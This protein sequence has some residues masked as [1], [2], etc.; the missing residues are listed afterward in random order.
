MVCDYALANGARLPAWTAVADHKFTA[1]ALA[2]GT[3][4][5][6]FRAAGYLAP[7]KAYLH[8]AGEPMLTR[9]LRALRSAHSIGRIRCVTPAAAIVTLPDALGLYD[10]VIE[11]GM[12]LIDSLLTGLAGLDP[13]ERVLL[14]AT[15][16]PLVT[17]SAIDA[18]AALA[19]A[20]PCDIGYGFVERTAHE[21]EYPE[22]RHT[23]VRLQQGV[24]CGGG[25][26]VMRAGA[27]RQVQDVL[28]RLTAAR[29]SPLKLAALFSYGLLFKAAM[30]WLRIEQ[31]ER[32]ADQISGLTCRGLLCDRPELA[33]NVDRLDDLRTVEHIIARR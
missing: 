10:E 27:A 29:K 16:M 4:E 32:R 22:V 2:G 19:S 3:L 14:A 7:N 8:V 15:D 17:A 26:S 31:V 11:P 30:G 6:D 18:F 5:P 13:N 21:R 12:G 24:F 9:V 20:T 1:V 28:R 23:W 25:V 33:V